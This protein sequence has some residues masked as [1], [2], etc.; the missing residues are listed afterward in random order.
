MKSYKIKTRFLVTLSGVEMLLIF[1][2][3][4]FLIVWVG[5]DFAQPDK[6]LR[7]STIKFKF[8]PSLNKNPVMNAG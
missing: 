5:F 4:S 2:K 1:F 3:M 6:I 8:R 7:Y